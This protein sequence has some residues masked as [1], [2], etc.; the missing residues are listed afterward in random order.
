M[1]VASGLHITIE[2]LLRNDD[3]RL[4]FHGTA[5]P[6]AAF[7]DAG[8]GKGEDCNSA[9]GL[10]CAEWPS[11]AAEYAETK[12]EREKGPDAIVT[13]VLVPSHQ[14]VELDYYQFFGFDEA[15]NQVRD[16]A[17]F[18]ELRQ[19]LILAG[20]DIVDFEDS[21]GPYS[22]SLVP[23]KTIVVAHLT[24]EQANVLNAKMHALS[25]PYSGLDR[26]E[27]LQQ[28]LVPRRDLTLAA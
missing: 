5:N 26:Y 22:I 11:L 28:V 7:T 27:V 12:A 10:S 6:V 1:T 21:D 18:E 9:L 2:D 4:M 8:L 14:P 13:A 20:Y 15:G 23:I 25:D 17:G 19:S 16:H 3:W 24:I